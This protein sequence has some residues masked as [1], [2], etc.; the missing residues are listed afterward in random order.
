[1]F[2]L[3]I[4]LLVLF[5]AVLILNLQIGGRSTKLISR[6]V[7]SFA[8]LLAVFIPL[9]SKEYLTRY[10]EF[11]DNYVTFNS[12][13]VNK[14]VY[15]FNVKYEDI[16]SLEA[17][18]I[19]VVGIYKVKVNA[20]NLPAN[21]PVTYCISKHNEMFATLCEKVEKANPKVYIDERIIKHLE[22]KGYRETD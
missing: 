22:K 18:M 6:T 9:M 21:I 8:G 15:N 5:M 10:V 11:C 13:R 2:F 3:Q 12:Y 20:K 7:F 16:L 4:T 19:P 1:M 14:R 17:T